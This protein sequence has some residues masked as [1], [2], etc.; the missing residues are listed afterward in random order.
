MTA[1][2]ILQPLTVWGLIFAVGAINALIGC[3]A[4]QLV[5]E[6][7]WMDILFSRRQWLQLCLTVGFV[8]G[9]SGGVLG[10]ELAVGDST[11]MLAQLR[12]SAESFP[13]VAAAFTW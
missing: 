5:A 13:L 9:I 2:E 10:A 11:S 4:G 12:E 6:R 1:M 7:R 3:A 8:S